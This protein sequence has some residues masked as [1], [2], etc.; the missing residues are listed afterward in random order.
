MTIPPHDLAAQTR[1]GVRLW[2]ARQV[3]FLLILAIVLFALAG[4][5]DWTMG[6]IQVALYVVVVAVQ[7]LLLIPRNPGLIAERSRLQEGT[8]QWDIVLASLA[9]AWL[10]IAAWA[11]AALDYRYGW[12]G[13][14][15]PAISAAAV[16]FWLLGYGWVLW[17]MAANPFFSATVRIQE[18]RGHRLA[19]HGPYRLVRHPG[20]AGAI[21][22]QMMTPL[23]LGSW[24]A[25]LPGGLSALLYVVRAALEDRFL[26]DEL[27]GYAEYARRVRYRLLPGI[28]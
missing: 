24:W 14:F 18:E 22:F 19:S 4:R 15:H 26:Q 10:P 17:A 3:A 23:L 1:A 11:V 28:W 7:A 20:Y 27:A 13:G 5:L 25:F 16:L 2:L 9:A 12:S 21:L 6:W 8:Q